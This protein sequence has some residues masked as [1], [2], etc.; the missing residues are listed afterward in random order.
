M[1]ITS[2]HIPSSSSLTLNQTFVT[3][4]NSCCTSGAPTSTN[5]EPSVPTLSP[6]TGSRRCVADIVT[7]CPLQTSL[8]LMMMVVQLRGKEELG[9]DRLTEARTKIACCLPK[10]GR[11]QLI[12]Q[13]PKML[14]DEVCT[15]V[16]ICFVYDMWYQLSLV[17]RHFPPPVFD[18]LQYAKR[19]VSWKRSKTGGGNG[20]GMR[21]KLERTPIVWVELAQ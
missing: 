19:F 12:R 10:E 4:Q 15:R 5:Q 21:L 1:F 14:V 3:A 8:V 9:R 2:T 16:D 20:L 18:H 7:T 13:R 11:K 6:T 17:P